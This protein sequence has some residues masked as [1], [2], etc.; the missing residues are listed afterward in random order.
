MT[1]LQ[2]SKGMS[3]LGY[4]LGTVL[5]I[6]LILHFN[7]KNVF[8]GLK[9]NTT[10]KT[11]KPSSLELG[12]H[13]GPDSAHGT[14][15][16]DLC[17]DTCA[18]LAGLAPCGPSGPSSRDPAHLE[19]AVCHGGAKALLSGLPAVCL[20]RHSLSSPWHKCMSD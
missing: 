2:I 7:F 5:F 20:G 4:F 14:G 10:N 17:L 6:S 9:I 13:S 19:A 3:K 1:V 16:D 12:P 18:A 11:P 15:R 8:G